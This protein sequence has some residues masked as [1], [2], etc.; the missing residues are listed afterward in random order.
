MI[1]IY[2][3]G[4]LNYPHSVERARR[5]FPDLARQCVTYTIL[6]NGVAPNVLPPAALDGHVV[7]LNLV[8]DYLVMVGPE[9]IRGAGIIV[10]Y[11]VAHLRQYR[12]ALCLVKDARLN[13]V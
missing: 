13:I 4:G 8:V 2:L 11:D 10:N 5:G 12:F 6:A 1:I 3:T 9:Q 7:V